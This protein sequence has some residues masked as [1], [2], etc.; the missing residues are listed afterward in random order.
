MYCT[1]K[2]INVE[3]KLDFT[4]IE[5]FDWDEGNIDKNWK[6]HL[7]SNKEAEE[8]FINKRV[9]YYDEKHSQEEKRFTIYGITNNGR[10]LIVIFTIRKSRIRIISAR[11]QN[12]KESKKYEKEA[13][14]NS[15]I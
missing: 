10:K 7:I 3:N 12:S 1:I 11:N 15:Y 9:Y 2:Y 4:K 8:A 5:G 6:K 13:K 14:T